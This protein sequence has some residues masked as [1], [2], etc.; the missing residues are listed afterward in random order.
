MSTINLFA[1]GYQSALGDIAAALEANGED[2]V[3]TWLA[4]NLGRED[5]RPVSTR[6]TA[7]R[8]KIR[9]DSNQAVR[10][11]ATE[12]AALAE[13]RLALDALDAPGAD[14]DA[15]YELWT[16]GA[17]AP[18]QAGR[19]L[20][21]TRNVTPSP[22]QSV[23]AAIIEDTLMDTGHMADPHRAHAIE[24]RLRAAGLLAEAPPRKPVDPELFARTAPAWNCVTD[25]DGPHYL[26]TGPVP[27]RGTCLWCGVKPAVNPFPVATPE[28]RGFPF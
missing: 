6:L 22:G 17:F 20:A 10:N 25:S 23:T 28:D 3:R 8:T 7:V 9:E 1:Q 5:L 24:L 2:G 12:K 27:E 26:S 16:D 21:M 4:D 13:L 18:Q 15:V 11:G 14:P 19:S